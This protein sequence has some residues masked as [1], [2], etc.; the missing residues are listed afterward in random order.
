MKFGDGTVSHFKLD[1]S[2][3]SFGL[4]KCSNFQYEF[5]NEKYVLE[6]FYKMFLSGRSSDWYVCL[7]VREPGYRK[8]YGRREY[9]NCD[10][11]NYI[12]MIEEI[13]KRN[14][15]VVRLGDDSM[16]RLP[17]MPRVI[18]YPFTSM[19]SPLVDLVLIKNC[20]FYIGNQSGTWDVS[21]LFSKLTITSDMVHLLH[22]YPV[23]YGDIGI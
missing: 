22:V 3:I 21:N 17:H 1:F 2:C 14:G 16:K 19:K 8:D 20:K 10:I 11:M 23:K 13:T 7:H 18:D 5:R 12:P 6:E 9:R 15:Y 4:Q